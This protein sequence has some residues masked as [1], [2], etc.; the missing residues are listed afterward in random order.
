MK[1]CTISAEIK[2]TGQKYSFFLLFSGNY[3]NLL[4]IYPE[5]TVYNQK[6]DRSW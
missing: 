2:K 1:N 5:Y 3:L 6:G 4:Y